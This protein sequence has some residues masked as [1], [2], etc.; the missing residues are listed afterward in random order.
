MKLTKYRIL[1]ST[2]NAGEY[3][4]DQTASLSAAKAIIRADRPGRKLRWRSEGNDIC[5]Y[6]N[7]E[8]MADDDKAVARLRLIESDTA[9]A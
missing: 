3:V 4:G 6:A 8:D 7:T 2:R 5:A 9:A 1:R